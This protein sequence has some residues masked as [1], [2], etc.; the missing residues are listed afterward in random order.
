M[1]LPLGGKAQD[2]EHSARHFPVH[3]AFF[4]K[5]SRSFRFFFSYFNTL[6]N[7]KFEVFPSF[8]KFQLQ[9]KFP[10]KGIAQEKFC[11]KNMLRSKARDISLSLSLS[12]YIYIYI[13]IYSEILKSVFPFISARTQRYLT[14]I[15]FYVVLQFFKLEHY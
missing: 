13:Y 1:L 12:I 9:K 14:F 10:T 4:D 7:T 6:K 5:T 15:R 8:L 11:K 2:G 3:S